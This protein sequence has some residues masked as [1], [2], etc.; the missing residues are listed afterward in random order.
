MENEELGRRLEEAAREIEELLRAYL[1]REEGPQRT[2]LEAMNY[3]VLA[4]GKRLRPLLMREIY[5]LCGGTGPQI[6]P[7]LAAMEMIHTYSLIHDDLPAMDNDQY[8]RGRPATWKAYG[9]AMGILAGDG[10]LNYAYETALKAFSQVDQEDPKALGRVAKALETLSRE[11]GVWGM[12]G[13]QT[14]DVEAAA[15]G[16]TPTQETLLFIHRKKTGALLKASM[17]I[18]AI[19]AGADEALQEELGRCGEKIGLAFQIQDDILDVEGDSR[20]LGK[21]VGSDAASQKQTYVTLRGIDRARADAETLA[22]E[23]AAILRALP[24]EHDFLE[25]WILSLPHRRR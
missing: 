4:G 22:Q 2:V 15:A 7:F 17:Q 18:G 25:A 24:G 3:S 20:E 16:E 11:A 8:R 21:P 1:P 14:A 19:L 6:E 13:G 23:A 9:E 12:V 10:L 5:R